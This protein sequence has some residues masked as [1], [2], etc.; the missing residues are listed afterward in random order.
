MSA[1]SRRE[2]LYGDELSSPAFFLYNRGRMSSQ[3]KKIFFS[4][5]LVLF[6]AFVFLYLFSKN[7]FAATPCTDLDPKTETCL[8]KGK[9]VDIVD[10]AKL[11]AAENAAAAQPSTAASKP[12]VNP[13]NAKCDFLEGTCWIKEVLYNIFHLCVWL[14][15]IGMGIF[16][17]VIDVPT[18]KKIMTNP[19]IYEIWKLVRDFF[20]IFFILVLLL[21]AFATIFQVDKYGVKGGALKKI[22]LA[23]L[24][25]NFSY[26]IA[27]AII[28]FGNVLLY[29]F[30]NDIF[31]GPKIST[32]VLKNSGLTDIFFSGGFDK[33]VDIYVYLLS[34]IAMFIFAVSLL[35]LSITMLVRLVALPILVMFSPAGFAASAFPGMQKFS[36]DWWDKLIKYT[37]Y[38]PIAVFM[39]LIAFKFLSVFRETSRKDIANSLVGG[40]GDANNIAA[41][42]YFAIPIVFMWIA[43]T[44]AQSLSNQTASSAIGWA[45]KARKKL[46]G[47]GKKGVKTMWNSTRFPGAAK[48]WWEGGAKI[49]GKT[50]IPYINPKSTKA[51]HAKRDEKAAKLYQLISG[52]KSAIKDLR[53]KKTFEQKDEFKKQNTSRSDLVRAMNE[54]GKDPIKARAA[55]LLLSETNDIRTSGELRSAL[56]IFK[57]DKDKTA[58]ILKDVKFED[59]KF[60]KEDYAEMVK[61]FDGWEKDTPDKE[62]AVNDLMENIKGRMKKGGQAQIL[63][64]HLIAK[65]MGAAE[66]YEEVFKKF[67]A[68]DL[69]KQNV[70]ADADF[71]TY[72]DKLVKDD[73]KLYQEALKKMSKERRKIWSGDSS[74]SNEPQFEV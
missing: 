48:Q 72:V 56:D 9:R 45:N 65:G 33:S 35:V 66:A 10:V 18:F 23:A 57:N 28:D 16:S 27:L 53:D 50:A 64:Q 37:F 4:L 2:I 59:L 30:V 25:I 1:D 20:N 54:S 44:T 55:A 15:E 13:K 63:A 38:G 58:K 3:K 40:A 60:K 41:F 43:I 71:N 17:Y 69:S 34:I 24:F 8:Y 21:A 73:A 67:N 61:A 14:A 29:S 52:D 49:R 42:V 6:I 19:V 39:L 26:P 11:Q 62:E 12:S 68:D 36:S 22:V 5:F 47:W 32:E 46:Q 31:G 51:R 70:T 7:V 74:Q